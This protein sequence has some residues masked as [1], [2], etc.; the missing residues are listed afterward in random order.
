LTKGLRRAPNA[1]DD[2]SGSTHS[3]ATTAY[4]MNPA[5]SEQTRYKSNT[6]HNESLRTADDTS[7]V[8]VPRPPPV[9]VEIEDED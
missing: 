8:G 3:G 1:P 2:E 7:R 9:I 5:L 4:T 6:N